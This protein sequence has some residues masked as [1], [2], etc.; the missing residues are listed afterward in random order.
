MLVIC[1]SSI[2]SR[3][4]FLR[5]QEHRGRIYPC[6]GPGINDTPRSLCG[7]PDCLFGCQGSKLNF[8]KS[9]GSVCGGYGN[10]ERNGS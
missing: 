9:R 5:P 3:A 7:P 10:V 1:H 8:A 4:V 2:S 6:L